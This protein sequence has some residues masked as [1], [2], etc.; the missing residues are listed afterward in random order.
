MTNLMIWLYAM[1]HAQFYAWLVPLSPVM[2]ADGVDKRCDLARL[3]KS[4]FEW[5][6]GN[7]R[8]L[9]ES[10]SVGIAIGV[11]GV[12]AIAGAFMVKKL[13]GLVK[14]VIIIIGA[15]LLFVSLVKNTDFLGT[16]SC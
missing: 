14:I 9:V 5:I 1:I 2:P 12:I 6:V 3:L 10:Y 7:I 16:S 11:V 13:P 15:V 4:P 8:G